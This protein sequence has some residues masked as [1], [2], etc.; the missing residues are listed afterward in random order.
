MQIK[1]GNILMIGTDIFRIIY[2]SEQNATLCQM[3]ISQL[4]IVEYDFKTLLKDLENQNVILD[5]DTDSSVVDFRRLSASQMETFVR[6]KRIVNE[7]ARLYG[8]DYVN[9]QGKHEKPEINLLLNKENIG[10]KAFWRTIRLYLQSGMKEA[11]LVPFFNKAERNEPVSSGKKRGARGSYGISAGCAVD[12]SVLQAFDEGLSHYKFGRAKSIRVA[13]NKMNS[14][15][16]STNSLENGVFSKVL[17]PEDQRPTFRQFK[18][19]CQNRLT[20]MDKDAIKTSKAE[21]RNNKRILLGEGKSGAEY[22]GEKVECDAVEFDISLVSSVDSSQA[23]GRPVVYVMR[24]VLTH[25]V[26]A[27]SVAFD[28][29]SMLGLT[30]LFLNLG[31]NKMELCKK[32]GVEYSNPRIWPSNFLP[33]EL[34]AD[35]GSD[36]KSDAFGR[37]CQELGIRRH[38]VSGASGSLKGTIESWFHQMHSMINPYTENCGLIEQRHDS[39]HHREST[40]NVFQFTK[41]VITCILLYNQA[42]MNDYKPRLSEV[43]N[44]IDSTPAILWEYYCR[45][46]GAPR[47]I[48]NHTDYLFHLLTSAHAKVSRKGIEFKGLLFINNRDKHLVAQMYHLQNNK[49]KIDIRYDPR[50]NSKIYYLDEGSHLMIA[51][52]NENQ[53]WMKDLKGHTWS[54]TD[55]YFHRVK[56]QSLASRQRNEEIGMAMHDMLDALVSEARSEKTTYSKTKNMRSAR[57]TEKQ[58]VS[59]ANAIT[60]RLPDPVPVPEDPEKQQEIVQDDSLRCLTDDEYLKMV[61]HFYEGEGG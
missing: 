50:D 31:D 11:A 60:D 61:S 21:Q 38:L 3:L 10:R 16:F 22:P 49:G 58:S 6:K 56:Q 19:Y 33:Q 4:N 39:D 12:E 8:P 55:R 25:A 48:V 23:I 43:Q 53:S 20:E 1:I 18:Y 7:V 37:L 9:L 35:R 14:D 32:Y 15:H 59:R 41:M 40:L 47:P 28:N 2:L 52:L 45:K 17:L 57:E 51:H 24:D 36:F 54:D 30:N 29:N 5:E 34:Y 27:V 46:N 13:Y 44:N 42:H 26:V